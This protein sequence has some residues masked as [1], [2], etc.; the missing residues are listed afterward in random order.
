MAASLRCSALAES[1]NGLNQSPAGM[2]QPIHGAPEFP[3]GSYD[4]SGDCLMQQQNPPILAFRPQLNCIGVR[5]KRLSFIIK[6]K[7]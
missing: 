6:S 5:T 4:S 1:I 7:V 2:K 3:A